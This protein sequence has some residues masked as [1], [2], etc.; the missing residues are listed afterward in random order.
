MMMFESE[1][2]LPLGQGF[3]QVKHACRRE[4]EGHTFGMSCDPQATLGDPRPG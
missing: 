4:P 2:L 1:L 3:V